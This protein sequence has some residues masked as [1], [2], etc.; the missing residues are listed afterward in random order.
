MRRPLSS[1]RPTRCVIGGVVLALGMSLSACSASGSEGSSATTVTT[2]SA[3]SIPVDADVCEILARPAPG[4][5]DLERLAADRID[6]RL[7]DG[8]VGDVLLWFAP[9]TLSIYLDAVHDD[10]DLAAFAERVRRR[11]GAAEVQITGRAASYAQFREL[12]ADQPNMLESVAPDQLPLRVHVRLQR[13][14]DLSSLERWANGEPEVYEV[15]G[16]VT[17][18]DLRT[19]LAVAFGGDRQREG[20]RS[21]AD[22]LA[23]SGEAWGDDVRTLVDEVLAEGTFDI[24]SP[25]GH[26]RLTAVQDGVRDTLGRCD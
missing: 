15:R 16:P 12:F 19:Q 25:D 6:L 3:A 8:A 23:G 18:V 13:P 10:D 17:S 22:E 4:P 7:G 11:P 1:L 14:D 9:S 2:T 24:G 20:W 21:L 26:A 5:I